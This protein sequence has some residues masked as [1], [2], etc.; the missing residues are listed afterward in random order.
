MEGVHP[1]LAKPG[2]ER[3][4]SVHVSEEAWFLKPALAHREP[5]DLREQKK[6]QAH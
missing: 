5:C 1:G 3:K 6:G 2:P 4:C